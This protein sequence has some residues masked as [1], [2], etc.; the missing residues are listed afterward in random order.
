MSKEIDI[1]E[2]DEAHEILEQALAPYLD[3]DWRLLDY[4]DYNARLSRG[5]RN[6]HIR[7]G[8]LGD[9]ETTETELTVTQ[10]TGALVAWVLLIAILLVVLALAS[11]LGILS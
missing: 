11:A 8:W 1:I 7:V 3:D 6:L 9:V 4:D 2:P 10:T 5:T